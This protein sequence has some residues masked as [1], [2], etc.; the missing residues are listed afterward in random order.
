MPKQACCIARHLRFIRLVRVDGSAPDI[1][2]SRLEPF[3]V[4]DDVVSRPCVKTGM[5]L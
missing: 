3:D 4:F 5:P 2:W 1:P